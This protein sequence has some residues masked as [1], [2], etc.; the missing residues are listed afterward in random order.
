M[1]RCTSVLVEQTHVRV[2]KSNFGHSVAGISLG[3]VQKNKSVFLRTDN[4][5]VFIWALGQLCVTTGKKINT[6]ITPECLGVVWISWNKMET[7]LRKW[8]VPV[9]TNGFCLWSAVA[10]SQ[11]GQAARRH[12]LRAQRRRAHGEGPGQLERGERE[13]PEYLPQCT[14]LKE[15]SLCAPN[16]S[17]SRKSPSLCV[18][19]PGDHK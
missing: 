5:H 17:Q 3:L 16:K 14:V 9:L 10:V 15:P 19:G 7:C 18:Q 12:Q 8:Y 13:S 6:C 1:T 4:S 2:Y 11:R